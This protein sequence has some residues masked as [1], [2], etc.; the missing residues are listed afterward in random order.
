MSSFD[1]EPQ[2]FQLAKDLGLDWQHEP[3]K[4]IIRMCLARLEEWIRDLDGI[5]SIEKLQQIAQDKLHLVLEEIWEDSELDSLVAKYVAAG[6]YVFAHLKSSLDNYTFAELLRRGN[7]PADA[8]DQ[9]VAI[10][11]C[12]GE[13]AARRFF[14]R[15]HEIAHMLTLR[16]KDTLPFNRDS[17]ERCP[18][19]RLMDAI[20]GEIAFYGPV[21]R[22]VLE[23]TL[24]RHK[25]LSFDALED[26]RRYHNPDASLTSTAIAAIRGMNTPAIFL[27]AEM[28]L[29]KKERDELVSSQLTLF[30]MKPPEEKLR[31]SIAFNNDAAKSIGLRIS[32]NMRIPDSSVVARAMCDM[33]GRPLGGTEDLSTWTHSDG[34][35]LPSFRVSIEARAHQDRV[36]ALVT[37]SS[38]SSLGKAVGA[39][40]EADRGAL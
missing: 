18:I 2:V 10:V 3:A 27:Q 37:P 14:T 1:Q 31:A 4:A 20:A 28:A 19:E 36:M 30:E 22:P 38:V 9:Y 33:S 8:P 25:G 5:H 7:V 23:S 40:Q 16:P 13:K 21:F 35:T 12:R 15:W 34:S 29:K 32:Q 6:D 17:K 11:D 26:L 39:G 24:D